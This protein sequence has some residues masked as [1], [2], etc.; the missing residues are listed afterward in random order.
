MNNRLQACKI[1]H[2]QNTFCA[3]VNYPL[4]IKPVFYFLFTSKTPR[5]HRIR[6]K[7]SLLRLGR[8]A[9]RYLAAFGALA[10]RCHLHI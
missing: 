8:F 4:Q 5:T 9:L 6:V 2:P 10:L 7:S 1:M 3:I